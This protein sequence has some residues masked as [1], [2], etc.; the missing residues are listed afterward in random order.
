MLLARIWE[1]DDRLV[2]TVT[3]PTRDDEPV[4]SGVELVPA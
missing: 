1:S 3:A 2:A 4:L